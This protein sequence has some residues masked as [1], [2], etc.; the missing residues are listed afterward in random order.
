[1]AHS[2][3]AAVEDDVRK[4]LDGQVVA[5][6]KK[7]LAGYM[8]GYWNNDKL[9]FFSGGTQTHGWKDTLERYQQRYQ[10]EGKEMGA[11]SFKELTIEPLGKA[12]AMAHGRW[13]LTL[14]DGKVVDGLFTVVLRKFPDGWR[15]VHD[16]SSL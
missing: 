8:A 16:H 4:L 3:H 9:T 12:A 11:L 14:T 10:G 5:W 7:D 1:L 15:I 2:A 6:N 13:K